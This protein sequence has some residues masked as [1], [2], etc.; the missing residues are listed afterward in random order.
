LVI[1]QHGEPSDVPSAQ[2]SQRPPARR[3]WNWPAFVSFLLAVMLW[4]GEIDSMEMPLRERNFLL[5]WG[6]FAVYSTIV[7]VPY[8]FARRRW[9]QAPDEWTG[10]GYL[11][12]IACILV[13]NTVWM[14]C[15]FG[16][17]LLYGR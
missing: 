3:K 14:V 12:A 11:N 17:G 13:C 8:Y 1:Q 15:M 4:I 6:V 16:V 7:L 2:D 10:G 5:A 9:K